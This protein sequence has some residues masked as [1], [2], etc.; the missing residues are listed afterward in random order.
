LIILKHYNGLILFYTAKKR[1]FYL[2]I[3]FVLYNAGYQI[4][5]KNESESDNANSAG[6]DKVEY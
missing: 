3:K 4:N 5:F 6:D 1:Q 2:G